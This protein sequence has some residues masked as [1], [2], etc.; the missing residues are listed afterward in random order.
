[1]GKTAPPKITPPGI[2]GVVQRKRLF[3]LLDA[4]AASPVIW[5][6]SSAGSGKTKFIASYLDTSQ[7]PCIWYQC[8]EGDADPGAFFYYMALAA[9]NA[10]PRRRIAL[11]L[12]TPEYFQGIPAFARRYFE[13]LYSL[14][15]PRT[16]VK[17]AQRKFFIVLDDYQDVPA[18]DSFHNMIAEALENAPRG[19]HIVIISRNDPPV[20]FARLKAGGRL[21]LLR[22]ADLRFTPEESQELVHS[23]IPDFNS[24]QIKSVH[25]V[26]EGWAT[27]IV[28]L[29]E[30]ARREGIH[31]LPCTD[32]VTSDL[33][34]YF[35]G[36]I[37]RKTEKAIQQFLLKTA[38]LPSLDAAR[39]EQLTG[40][41]HAETILAD[42]ARHNYFTERL[43]GGGDSYRYHPL[44]RDYLTKEA[45]AFFR[46]GELSALRM[47]A[48]Q[49]EE[50]SGNIEDAARLYG[51]AREIP[52]LARIVINYARHFLM[53]GRNKTVAEWLA[54]IPRTTVADNSWLL[55]WSGL[56]SFPADM[57]HTRSCMEKA[58]AA[59]RRANDPAGLY[60][61]W[62]GVVDSYSHDFGKWD[63]LD[64]CIEVFNDLQKK[65]PFPVS[66]EI[67]LIASSRILIL[68]I[69]RRMEN[70]GPILHWF[71]R[72]SR[73]L[74][75]SSFADI[76]QSATFYMSTYYLW[77][78]EY[79]ANAL[80]L[81]KAVERFGEKSS[82]LSVIS[83]RLMT[84]IHYWVTAQYEAAVEHLT[85]G[86]ALAEESGV[87]NYNSLLWSMLAAVKIAT[88][89]KAAAEQTL[90]KQKE[91]ALFTSNTLDMFFYHIN[92]AWQAL[93][94]ED[95]QLAAMHMEIIAAPAAQMGHPYYRALWQI[96][97]A[98]IMYLQERTND[99][100]TI[101][102]RAYKIGRNMKSPV[103]E[104]YS[105]LV[106]AWFFFGQDAEK[107]G[108]KALRR[109][110]ALGRKHGYVHL[111]F[112]QPAVMRFLCAKSLEQ[113]IEE[114]YAGSLIKKLGLTPPVSGMP[115]GHAAIPDLSRWPYSVRICTL[116]R[117][118]VFNDNEQL[119]NIGRIQKKPLEMLKALI[120]AGA[121]HVSAARLAD[122]LWPDAE[123]DLA[124]KSFE[125]TLSRLRHLFDKD[126]ILYGAGQLS[127]N[128]GYC[129]VDSMVLTGIIEQAGKAPSERIG[130]LCD[131]ALNLYQGHF[132]PDDT[133]LA[134][135]V[136]RR[137]MLKNGLL[138][139]ILKAGRHSEQK[140]ELEKAV[141]YFEA[142]LNIDPLTEEFYQHLMICYRKLGRQ[143]AAVKTYRRCSEFLFKQLGIKPSLATNAI[144][145]SLLE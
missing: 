120:A 32:A 59:F 88:G 119:Q 49:I 91:A 1:M 86:L 7:S 144:Y 122:E 25:K 79:N 73:P 137:E 69:L 80:L 36:E 20:A 92:S 45:K 117:F 111:E 62:A 125:V 19:I 106:A 94:N 121:A 133:T 33:F 34:D 130:G 15:L 55:Y 24:E 60:L 104:W 44:F 109:G 112:Y 17:S 72:I 39:T 74:H 11:P 5:V 90:Q 31:A 81:E 37:F 129:Q 93:T 70:A 132:L 85:A 87:H 136:H 57:I 68:L 6:S 141:G 18:E 98:Q 107:K 29:L 142:G 143:A 140:G 83:V 96:G 126:I 42:L 35:A 139:I 51:E 118:A 16:S 128:P 82:P 67:E 61:A 52:Q 84:G 99:A 50:E 134:W 95:A 66:E 113:G 127:I 71:D 89:N 75:H 8:D 10:V 30:Q 38:F 43:A 3:D 110:M 76:Y 145:S 9:R 124:R 138:Q 14:L 26:T 12:L 22:Y 77:K 47:K 101:I 100:Q 46:P 116:G 28:L 54:A 135:S 58:L 115:G 64:K 78:G 123:G 114:N 102:S 63:D 105:L 40:E 23:R 21:Y 65:Y 97:M 27:G 131:K 41:Q 2:S 53:Q 56:C 4:K 13:Q 108:L 48:A 103:I